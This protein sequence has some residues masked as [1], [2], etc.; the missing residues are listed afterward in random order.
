MENKKA[1][2]EYIRQKRAEAGLTQK[3]FADR[4]FVTESA[5]S[6]WERGLSY[7]DITLVGDIC[8]ILQI[9]EHELLTAS[10][11]VETRSL[12]KLAKRYLR[13]VNRFKIAQFLIYGIALVT[14]FICNLAVQHTL[15]WFFIVLTSELVAASLTLLPI[16]LKEKRGLY[17]LLGFTA[18]L[19]VLLMTCCL[20]THG[21]WFFV[22]IVPVLFG[23]TVAFLPY[24]L[25]RIWLPSPFENHKALLCMAVD[26][27]FLF[28]LLFI[29]DLYT[30]GGWFLSVA[31]PIA[32]FCLILPWGFLLIIRYTKMNRFL[33]TAGCLGV[34]TMFFYF[35]DGFLN[36]IL[37]KNN[38]G[39]WFDFGFNFLDWS[40]AMINVNVNAIIFFALIGCTLIFTVVGIIAELRKKKLT[41]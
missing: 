39:I 17:T 10:E 31:C 19:T 12:E 38:F 8:E 18:T 33:K 15:S 30:H 22:T 27:L 11:D 20:Y 41:A 29:C 23:L 14:C 25:S 16:L 6:K 36:I 5:V 26:S 3:G 4:L 24:V 9:N 37:E 28:L 7:P 34:F 1:F 32:G 13:L 21:D 2:G 40:E 35:L